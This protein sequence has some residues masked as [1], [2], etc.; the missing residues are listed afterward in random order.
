SI[1]IQVQADPEIF[2]VAVEELAVRVAA[3]VVL[4][5]EFQLLAE[6]SGLTEPEA[7]AQR[8]IRVPAVLL[9]ELNVQRGDRP[10]QAP[11]PRVALI[12]DAKL[13]HAGVQAVRFPVEQI[14]AATVDAPA[15]A[16][17]VG[18]EEV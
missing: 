11:I 9:P 1:E 12:L 16:E 6:D 7:G 5:G 14:A 18:Q 4:G 13:R 3:V 17:I 8:E 2:E 10:Q 15:L